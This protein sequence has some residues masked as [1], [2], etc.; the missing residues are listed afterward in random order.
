MFIVG[1]VRDLLIPEIDLFSGVVVRNPKIGSVSEIDPFL[2][3]NFGILL[4][5]S[6]AGKI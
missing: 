5:K 1:G 2:L 4:E 6:L 3:R